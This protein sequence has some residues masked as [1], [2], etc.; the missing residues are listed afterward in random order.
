MRVMFEDG[1]WVYLDSESKININGQFG[2]AE[3]LQ[4][5]DARDTKKQV[6]VNGTPEFFR[7]LMEKLA[8]AF[9]C[10]VKPR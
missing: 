6:I 7:E 10:D 3:Q 5:W 9:H 1:V 2:N 4:F 8:E